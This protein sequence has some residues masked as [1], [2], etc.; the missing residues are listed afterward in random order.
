MRIEKGII[1]AVNYPPL[2]LRPRS[3]GLQKPC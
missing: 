2:R 1:D 3:G